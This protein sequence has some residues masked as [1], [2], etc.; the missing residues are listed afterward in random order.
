MMRFASVVAL[1]LLGSAIPALAATF[2]TAVKPIL[3]KY[4]VSCHSGA[5]PKGGVNLAATTLTDRDLLE[6]AIAKI[7]S[8]EMPPRP[9]PRPNADP[10]IRYLESEW[11]REDR[12]RPLEP[13]RVTVRRLNRHEYNNTV[14]DLLG[15]D[16]KPA[17]EFPADDSGYGFD[18]IADVLS[19]S[20]ALLER[21]L[22]A[23]EKLSR[24]AIVV[25]AE[26]KPA[27]VTLK[28]KDAAAPEYETAYRFDWNAAYEIR[29]SV[30]GEQ[31]K[32]IRNVRVAFDLDGVEQQIFDVDIREDR[33]R[34]R[35]IRPVLASGDH[36]LRVRLLDVHP[37]LSINAI[38]VSGPFDPQPEPLTESHRRIIDCGHAYNQHEPACARRILSPLAM[39]AWRR[40]VTAG[41]VGRLATFVDQAQTKGEPFEAGLRL[42]VQAMLV[43]PNFLFRIENDPGPG[44]RQRRLNDYELASRL[45]YFLWS[46]MPDAQLFDAAARGALRTPAGVAWQVRRM[47]ADPKAFALA[48]NFAGQWL[49][50]RNLIGAKPDPDR[51]PSF[52]NELREAMK[53]ETE[54]VF[55]AALRENRSVL[56]LIDS[57]ETYLN[58]RLARHYRVQVRACSTANCVPDA[59]ACQSACEPG[60]TGAEFRRVRMAD[61]NRSGVLTHA[62]VLTVTSYPNRTSPVIRGKFLLETFLNAPPPPP[63][64]NVPS[65]DEKAIGKATSL[66]QQ[67]EQHRADPVCASCHSKMDPLGF[68]LENFDA[69]GQWRDR[70]GAFA[71]GTAGTLPNGQTF[72]GPTGLQ[73]VLAAHRGDFVR[74]LTE[75]LL[76][77]GTGRGL[78]RDDRPVVERILKTAASNDYRFQE[79][80]IAIANSLPFT[81]RSAPL[82]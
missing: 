19:L 67:L 77:Y 73:K 12:R 47:T 45:S 50:L 70:D 30:S 80:L 29:A 49:Q 51:F 8:G 39:R 54:L 14:R 11:A 36:R 34:S 16:V 26:P 59:V 5:M 78:T 42:A 72:E 20:P 24:A 46:S 21:Y 2:E 44:Q 57:R 58:E 9:L 71:I 52:D 15:V 28:R 61:P 35:G 53:R 74:G 66:R 1:S 82:P 4:C 13:G 75:K 48:E 65:L 32:G 43:S 56:F 10:A 63:P 79:L 27:L 31:P 6:R 33:Q 3:Q 76:I 25:R 60:L 7:K 55:A 23:A 62:S 68:A 37:G 64:A 81:H 22:R 38:E 18:N 40:P 41:E 17:D 69:I